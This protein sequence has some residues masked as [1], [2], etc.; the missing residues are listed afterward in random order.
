MEE[1]KMYKCLISFI[2]TACILG[3]TAITDS[4]TITYAQEKQSDLI[5][6]EQSFSP[7]DYSLQNTNEL[8]EIN[9]PN[10]PPQ[11]NMVDNQQLSNKPNLLKARNATAN[12]VQRY[13]V[14]VLDTSA[15]SSFLDSSGSVFYTADTA[16]EYVKSS[17]KKFIE[18][19][20]S[21]NGTNY[22]A[23]VSY[24]GATAT[25]VTGRP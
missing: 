5:S 11:V 22:I 24:K 4:N 7:G 2:L 23:I 1:S 20:H 17:A 9:L 13:T 10:N 8:S 14:L 19:V 15:S 12:N 18:G 3:S 6:I 21:A 25:V 16:V